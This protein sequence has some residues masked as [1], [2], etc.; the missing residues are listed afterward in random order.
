MIKQHSRLEDI[1]QIQEQLQEIDFQQ[2]RKIF[3]EPEV[4][5]VDEIVFEK[6]DYES[7]AN[8]LVKERSFSED[9]IQSTLNRLKKAL[10]RK[11]Q[12]LDQWF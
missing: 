8:Y 5:N 9:R 10:E 1:P 3:L 4:T 7:I 12:N 11:S 6:V 2:I